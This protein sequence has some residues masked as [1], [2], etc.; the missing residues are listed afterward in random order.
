MR[1]FIVS[2]LIVLSALQASFLQSKSVSQDS[3]YPPF[4]LKA[5]HDEEVFSSFRSKDIFRSVVE[6]VDYNQGV[7]FATYIKDHYY[8]LV[9]PHLD[10]ICAEDK[11]GKPGA[12]FFSSLGEISPTTLRYIKIAGDLQQEF[13]DIS[14]FNIIEIGGGYGGQCKMVYNLFG[15]KSYTIIDIPECTPLINKYLS[16]AVV[17]N[18]CAKNATEIDQL[19]AYD[20]II[21]NY[22]FSEI[23]RT[24]Q[25][26]YFNTIINKVPRGYI[27]YNSMPAID[28][29]S[30]D[31]FV[32]LLA[33]NH[34]NI[35]I[36]REIPSTGPENVLITWRP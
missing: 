5:A 33:K 2:F 24:E 18:A 29:L 11:I 4:C 31:E 26:D 35:C 14:N 34:P 16:K 6:T 21:S 10:K 13:G 7:A 20:L 30:V 36:E 32:A 23:E 19:A 27:I 1:F 17:K 8:Q 12:C 28:P 15:F 22:A 3:Y 25:L 9:M